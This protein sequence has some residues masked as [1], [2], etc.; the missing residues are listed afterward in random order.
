MMAPLQISSLVAH[1]NNFD[2]ASNSVLYGIDSAQDILVRVSDP[3]AGKLQTVGNLG[4]NA[5]NLAGF[6]IAGNDG[7]ALVALNPPGLTFSQ[8]YTL[9][10]ETGQT[11]LVG[12]ISDLNV[13]ITA[14]AIQLPNQ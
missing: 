6:D 14:L 9:N 5:S 2:S 12:T 8:L 13:P 10:L 11:T 7:L 4:V 1:T 3:A